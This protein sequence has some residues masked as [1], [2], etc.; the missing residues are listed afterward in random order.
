MPVIDLSYLHTNAYVKL[1][2]NL[3]YVIHF[4]YFKTL[5]WVKFADACDYWYF[6]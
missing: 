1:R 4:K 2:I 5:I 3:N 6:Y